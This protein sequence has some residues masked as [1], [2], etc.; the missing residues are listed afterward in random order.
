MKNTPEAEIQVLGV[1]ENIM[2]QNCK[3]FGFKHYCLANLDRVKKNSKK[4]VS[5]LDSPSEHDGN[6]LKNTPEA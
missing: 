6:Q 1:D 2:T 5:C 3:S 4:R